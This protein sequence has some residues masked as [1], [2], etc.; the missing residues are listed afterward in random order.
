MKIVSFSAE[1]TARI[2]YNMG[3]AAKP[4][5]I[6]CL[7][8]TLGAGKTVFSQGFARGLGYTGRVTS[9]TFTIMNTYEGGRLNL[10]HFDLYRLENETDLE[11]IGYEEYFY[12]DGCCLVEWPERMPH[13]D[14]AQFVEIQTFPDE[15]DK[16]EIGW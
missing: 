6:Y 14:N 4:G 9:P 10:Y 7:S 13:M 3:K 12:S 5:D 16:R 1:E 15:P 2:G 8:G 11:S